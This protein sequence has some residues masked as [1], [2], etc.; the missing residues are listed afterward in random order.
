MSKKI[1]FSL[2]EANSM[3]P[4][5]LEDIPKIKKLTTAL[6]KDFPDV[7]KARDKARFN[8]GSVEGPLYLQAAL[9]VNELIRELEAKGCVLKGVEDGLVD[10]LSIR[11]GREVY[12]CWKIPEERI[13]H[14][15][16]IHAGFSGRKPIDENF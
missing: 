12:L 4:K 9:K 10:F 2:E 16:D 6:Q 1:Y 8:G 7:Q 13:T 5:L 11:E 14:W 3:V 15:H